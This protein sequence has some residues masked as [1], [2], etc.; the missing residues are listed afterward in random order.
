MSLGQNIAT[1]TVIA[2]TSSEL[3]MHPRKAAL[4]GLGRKKSAFISFGSQKHYVK[5]TMNNE[6]SHESVLLSPKLI[7]ELHLPD[8]PIY[9]LCVNKNEIIIGPYIGLLFSEQA[10]KL[11]SSRLKKTMIY[12][13]DYSKLHGAVVVFA[14]DQVDTKSRLIEGYCYNPIKNFWQRGIFPYPTSIYRSIGLSETWKNHFLSVIGDKVFNN[15]YFNKWEMYQWF[16]KDCE[17]NPHIPYTVLYESPQDVLDL[18]DRF[19]KIY[20]KPVSGLRGRRIVKLSTENEKFVLK[21]RKQGVNCQVAFENSS[22]VSEYI[23]KHFYAGKYLIQQAIDLMEYK[24]GMID[25][26][27]VVQKNQANIWVCNAIIGRQG[28]KGSIVS[29]ISSGG[30]AFP[31]RDILERVVSPSEENILYWKEKMEFFAINVC[32][33]LDEYGINCGNL[34]LDIGIDKQGRLWLIEINNRDPDPTIALD[35]QDKQLYH[36][37]I[38]SPLFYAK[39]L[40]GFTNNE[41]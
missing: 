2:N 23:Q 3:N 32:R 9:E 38:T 33:T 18:L 21:Y 28:D 5:I 36:N 6:I 35:I 31:A 8:Y 16:S 39:S 17:I 26:R 11:T 15:H 30:T 41:I 29:N 13:R 7:E 20:I 27:C 4:I 19:K 12:L 22:E 1:I 14:L 25:F 10:K 34:G 37:L 40:A 24:G